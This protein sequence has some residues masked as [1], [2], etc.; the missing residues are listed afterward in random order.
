M[1]DKADTQQPP[2]A[3]GN[4]EKLYLFDKPKNVQRLLRGFYL[5]CTLLVLAEFVIHRHV[6]HSWEGLFGFYAIYGFVACVVLV[7]AATQMRKLIMRNEDYYDTDSSAADST[8]NDDGG[9][10]NVGR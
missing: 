4:G 3:A 6:V 5:C 9:N 10:G 2:S 8:A 7:L 1:I